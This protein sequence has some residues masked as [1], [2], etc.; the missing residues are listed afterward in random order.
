[1]VISLIQ[2]KNRLAEMS[3]NAKDLDVPNAG[4]NL[5]KLLI[6]LAKRAIR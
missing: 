2:D 3:A 5:A 6:G 4:D 1:M